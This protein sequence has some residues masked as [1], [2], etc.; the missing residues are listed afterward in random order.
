MEIIFRG[1]HNS[2][3]AAE[4][5]LTVLKLFKDRY[6]ISQFREMH[7]SVTLV[8]ARGDDVELVDSETSQA[9]RTFEVYRSGYELNG[10]KGQPILQLV[11][12]NT[13]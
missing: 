5:L 11:V 6:Q 2:E 10:K 9:F 13:R 7:L 8:D 3:E 4:S 12:D 1:L